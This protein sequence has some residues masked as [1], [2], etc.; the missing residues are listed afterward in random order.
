MRSQAGSK[1]R[2]LMYVSGVAQSESGTYVAA[3][4]Y[5][6]CFVSWWINVGWQATESLPEYWD[7][8]R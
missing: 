6:L 8:K 1:D 3:R 7:K 4:V 5:A 2:V